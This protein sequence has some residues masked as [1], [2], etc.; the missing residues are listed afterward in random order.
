MDRYIFSDSERAVLEGLTMPLAVYQYIDKRIVPLVL[1]EGFCRMIGYP[2]HETAYRNMN[3]DVYSLAHPDDIARVSEIAFRL[4]TEEGD[5]E[6]IY[7]TRALDRDAYRVIHAAGMHRMTETGVRLDYVWYTDEGPYTEEPGESKTR[8]NRAMNA[9]LHEE[10]LL[11]AGHYDHLTGLPNMTY[12]FE[13][14]EAGRTAIERAGGRPVLLFMNLSGMKYYNHK[15]GFSEGD[16][17]LKAFADLL[18]KTFSNE[19]CCHIAQDHFAAFTARE[20]L[21]DVLD[22]LL[23]ACAALN[24]GNSLPLHIGIYPDFVQGASAAMAC[25]RAKIACD[26]I[27]QTYSSGYDFYVENLRNDAKRRQYIQTNLDRALAERW[28]QVYY[29]PIIRAANQKVCDDE[30][31]SRWIHPE[32]GMISPAEFVPCLE[33]SGQIYKLDL[34]VLEQVLEKLRILKENGLR[35]VPHSI[36]LSRSDFDACDIVEEI[37]KR[38]DAAGVSRGLIAVEITESTIGSDFERMKQQV[39]RFRTLGF[40]VWLDDFGSGYSSLD[41]LQSIKFDL[42]KFDMSFMRKLDESENSRVVLTELVKLATTLGADTVCEGVETERQVQFLQEIGCTKLQGFYF[43]K[44]LPLE[45]VLERHKNPRI[46]YENPDEAPYY[47]AIGKINLY[48]LAVIGSDGESGL[49]T[50]F[51]TLPMGIIEVRGKTSR[52]VRSNQSYRDFVKRFLGFDLAREGTEFVPYDDDFMDN[53]VK[54]CGELGIKTFYDQQLPSGAIVHSFA[55]RIGVNPVNGTIAVAAAVLSISNA[56]EGATYASIARALAADYYNIY[57]VDLDTEHFIEYTSPRGREGLAMER[58]GEGFFASVTKDAATRIYAD[59]REEF[60]RSFTKENILR[61]LDDHGVFTISYRLLDSGTPLYAGMKITRMQPGGSQIIMGISII[62]AQVKQ[63]AEEERARQEQRALG[64]LAALAGN[65]VALYSVDPETGRYVEYSASEDYA[66][67]GL[68]K[69]GEDFFAKTREESPKYVPAEE[70]PRYMRAIEKSHMLEE[71]ARSGLF[72]LDYHLMMNGV[73]TPVSLRAALVRE[74]DGDKLIVGISKAAKQDGH[75]AAAEAD[76]FQQIVDR[77]VKPCAIL[78]VEKG[79]DGTAGM[80]RIVCANKEY[81]KTMGS[82]YYDNM[83]YYELV[84]KVLRFENSCYRCAIEHQ[85]VHVYTQT[86]VNELWTDQQLI[87]L[88]SDREDLGYCEFILE[89]SEARDR[90]RMAAVPVRAATSVLRAAITLLGTNDLKERVGTVLSDIME[91]SEAFSVRVMLVDHENKRAINYCDRW[92]IEL[93]DDYVPPEEDPDQAMIS[94]QLICSWEGC[95]GNENILVVTSEEEM[96]E[97][98]PLNPVWVGTMRAY[99]VTTFILIPLRHEKEIIGYLYL[100]NFNP[101]K[102]Q[103]IRELAELM[104]FFLGTEIYNE[105]LLKRLDEMSHTDALTGLGNRNSMIQRTNQL[106]QSAAKTPFGVVNLDM[107]GLKTVNDYQ[108]HDAGD[109]LLIQAADL[110]KRYFRDGDLYRIGGDEFIIISTG[111]AEET[112]N[113]RL[114]Q[115]RAANRTEDG[116]LFSI[117]AYW[118]DGETDVVSAFR[119]A[120]ERMYQDKKAYYETHP[121]QRR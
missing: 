7:R 69:E 21:E 46:G 11:K 70:L 42:I 105:V 110:L 83:P 79:P 9:A 68:A 66:Q 84:P 109:A 38:V 29:Q 32:H 65:Y 27:K 36:N 33:D 54:S 111:I 101:G 23:R 78:S 80:I 121:E 85:Q 47:E 86:K 103:D 49:K 28:I 112:F 48:D 113:K 3:H 97:L 56:D 81:K 114:D 57:Y 45:E 71:I 63:K 90:D 10:S 25:D 44:P 24:G 98:E 107:N 15:Y 102:V 99:G 72:A 18:A 59:D 58:H 82:K 52:F 50:F 67:Y 53:V 118:S 19:S 55:R 8:L 92:A 14:A 12:F 40:P 120:D 31:L 1:S 106:V 96:S 13:L 77:M 93:G 117:G 76:G 119:Q 108:G 39:E 104:S 16:R 73:L 91:F 116:A 89:M 35:L 115:L 6:V 61:E 34:Y 100:C 60:L 88:A 5:R 41:V 43:S 95:I 87:P 22:E 17:L 51:N 2:D 26:A 20:G 64:R 62:D 74:G 4:A 94:Y 37:V 30:A 75:G